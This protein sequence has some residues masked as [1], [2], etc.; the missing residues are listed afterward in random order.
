METSGVGES[1]WIPQT[2]SEIPLDDF[3]NGNT[4]SDI[5]ATDNKNQ[6]Y[7][8]PSPGR[9]DRWNTVPQTLRSMLR[10]M[11]R[12]YIAPLTW[13]FFLPAAACL[14]VGIYISTLTFFTNDE[15]W[16][17]LASRECQ[18]LQASGHSADY[19]SNVD[20]SIYAGGV[21]VWRDVSKW[22]A[23]FMIDIK[24]PATLR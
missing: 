4:T 18:I 2:P 6:N 7:I 15:S 8:S 24:T 21:Q 10:N 20:G 19:T 12:L 16:A 1:K 17:T 5:T 3:Y 23:A 11:K 9:R 22:K 13:L 14:G